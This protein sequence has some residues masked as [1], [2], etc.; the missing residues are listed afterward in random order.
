[1]DRLWGCG[2]LFYCQQN[3]CLKNPVEAE[4]LPLNH[5]GWQLGLREKIVVTDWSKFVWITQTRQ[6]PLDYSVSVVFLPDD[7]DKHSHT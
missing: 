2:V 4:R 3:I 7:D 1:M 6:N 5:D